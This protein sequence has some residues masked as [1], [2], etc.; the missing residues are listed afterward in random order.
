MLNIIEVNFSLN[1]KT[2]APDLLVILLQSVIK[3]PRFI[4]FFVS[5][6]YGFQGC[7]ADLH[8]A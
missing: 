2:D 8:Q 4:P 3:G 6:T 1:S 5:L 7:Y